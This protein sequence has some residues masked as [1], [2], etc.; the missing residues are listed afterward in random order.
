LR[1]FLEVHGGFL[2]ELFSF[3]AVRILEQC[4]EVSELRR[5]TENNLTASNLRNESRGILWKSNAQEK[6]LWVPTLMFALFGPVW[7]CSIGTKHSS[8]KLLQELMWKN[9]WACSHDAL[10]LMVTARVSYFKKV[11]LFI[12]DT[13][14]RC[15]A[16]LHIQN[17]GHAPR[18]LVKFQSFLHT[19]EIDYDSD[20]SWTTTVLY[21]WKR[22]S[23][24][25]I[26]IASYITV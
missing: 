10:E 18:Y 24:R 15:F 8:K 7:P 17:D 1:S 5:A 19:P 11:R 23:R 26:I 9:F 14:H 20:N 22:R 2:C 6:L 13:A 25:I 21:G 4:F 16:Y 3:I 12:R